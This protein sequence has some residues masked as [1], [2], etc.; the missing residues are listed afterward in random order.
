[1]ISTQ[2]LL[3]QFVHPRQAVRTATTAGL[4][5]TNHRG[6]TGYIPGAATNHRGQ[7]GYIPGATT[8]H[9]GQSGYIQTYRQTKPLLLVSPVAAD[10]VKLVVCGDSTRRRRRLFS[11]G[12]ALM[13]SLCLIGPLKKPKEEYAEHFKAMQMGGLT[14]ANSRENVSGPSDAISGPLDAKQKQKASSQRAGVPVKG[15][16]EM[17]F[18]KNRTVEA[19][20]QKV[21]VDASKVQFQVEHSDSKQFLSL[22]DWAEAKRL[23]GTKPSKVRGLVGTNHRG[24]MGYIPGAGT[25][26]RGQTGYIQTVT[27]PSATERNHATTLPGCASAN[28]SKR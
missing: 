27:T 2:V 23:A 9:R 11:A 13:K 7:T 16:R 12:S 26:H 1:M 4:V 24:R 21:N 10:L 8:N 20:V 15:T 14:R 6:R 19:T 18:Y 17:I 5:G 22:V 3:S 28:T 25:N